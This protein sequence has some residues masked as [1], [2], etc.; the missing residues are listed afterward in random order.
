MIVSVDIMQLFI[1]VQLYINLIYSQIEKMTQL[2][3]FCAAFASVLII[4]GLIY[5]I[6]LGA[7]GV[8]SIMGWDVE[9]CVYSGFSFS[10][11]DRLG[12]ILLAALI[13]LALLTLIF[14]KTDR[15][16]QLMQGGIRCIRENISATWNAIWYSKL[17]YIL[18]IPLITYVYFAVT[19]PITHDEATTYIYYISSSV[20]ETI[21]LYTMPNNHILFS[22]LAKPFAAISFIDLQLAVRLPAILVS[23]LTWPI[24]YRFVRKFYSENTAL[25]VTAISSM[26]SMIITYS[27]FSRGYSMITFFVVVCLYAAYNIINEGNKV[28]HWTIFTISGILGFY[29]IPT[30][31]YPFIAIN[32]FILIYNYKSI[33][34]QIYYNILLG[35]IT[36]LLYMPVFIVM[37]I[38][39]ITD[40]S[41]VE[42][43]TFS[44]LMERIYPFLIGIVTDIYGIVYYVTIPVIVLLIAYSIMQKDRRVF[45]LWLLFLGTP[46]VIIF[47]QSMIPFTRTFC[48]LGVIIIL[49]T[50]ILF[51]KQLRKIS[52][53]KLLVALVIIQIAGSIHFACRSQFIVMMF[54]SFEELVNDYLTENKSYAYRCDYLD[55]NIRFEIKRRGLKNI[56]LESL[57]TDSVSADTIRG[58]DYIIIE[59]KNDVTK[60]K[61]PTDTVPY[62]YQHRILDIYYDKDKD[63]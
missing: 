9:N 58:F 53:R 42:P 54:A 40:N 24:L 38:E 19:L 52:G 34:K 26:G 57:P 37:G 7:D 13:I 16:I 8:K 14:F 50:G 15:F 12:Y 39:A 18:P 36:Y 5:C 30:F 47:G 46:F 31:L 43:L 55:P 63:K 45:I 28:R 35:A 1:F 32:L 2:V 4:I 48:Y 60:L 56:R 51:D 22:L 10:L 3:K 17:K 21:S 25:A 62:G 20:M 49:L 41:F 27:V 59:R 33:G 11:V 6:I 29:T 23:M 44:I 61:Q